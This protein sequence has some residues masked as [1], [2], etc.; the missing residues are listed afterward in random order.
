M[1]KGYIPEGSDWVN[2]E[3]MGQ[4]DQR[5]LIGGLTGDALGLVSLRAMVRVAQPQNSRQTELLQGTD[6]WTRLTLVVRLLLSL[7][8]S[9]SSV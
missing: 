4:E 9:G 5:E 7:G 3:V 6:A 8:C 2:S 1:K